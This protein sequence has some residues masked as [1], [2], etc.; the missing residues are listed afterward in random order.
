MHTYRRKRRAFEIYGILRIIE[1]ETVRRDVPDLKTVRQCPG[2]KA[3]GGAGVGNKMI[4]GRPIQP[5]RNKVH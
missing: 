5:A 3:L 4:E 2:V 1:N